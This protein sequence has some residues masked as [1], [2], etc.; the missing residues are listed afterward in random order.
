MIVKDVDTLQQRLIHIMM[1]LEH[2][3]TNIKEGNPDVAFGIA[4]K[5]IKTIKELF[6]ENFLSE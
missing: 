4:E 1:S 6:E 3:K 5:Q 2:I